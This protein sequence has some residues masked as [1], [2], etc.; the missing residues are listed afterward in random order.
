[1]KELIEKIKETL[2]EI[3]NFEIDSDEHEESFKEML[4]DCEA[5]ISILGVE[6]APTYVLQCIDPIAYREGLLNYVDGLEVEDDP[7]YK[8]L[9]E[10]LEEMK[11]ELADHIEE[12]ESLLSDIEDVI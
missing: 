5:K 7:D 8:E 6:Y 4:D 9:V 10:S 12:M 11:D 2:T 3:E 1:M